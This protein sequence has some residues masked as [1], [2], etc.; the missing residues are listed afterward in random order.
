MSRTYQHDYINLIEREI[1]SLYYKREHPAQ[2]RTLLH[3]RKEMLDYWAHD[4]QRMLYDEIKAFNDALTEALSKL[5]KEAHDT[6][7]NVI[8]FA[9]GAEITAQCFLTLE[10]P[11]AFNNLGLICE[12]VWYALTDTEYNSLYLHGASFDELCLP[13]DL[14]V[15]FNHFIGLDEDIDWI[16]DFLPELREEGLSV[17][18][19]FYNLATASYFAITDFICVRDFDTNIEIHIETKSSML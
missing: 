15:S 18:N 4:H 14:D 9:P 11:K 16:P 3:L 19:A 17:N 6:Y 13:R 1:V 12:E 7:D 8:R 10:K 2:L 5:Y